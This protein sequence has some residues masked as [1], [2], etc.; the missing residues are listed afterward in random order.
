[1]ARE[2]TIKLEGE[3]S[4]KLADELEV[5]RL[6]RDIT[7]AGDETHHAVLAVIGNREPATHEAHAAVL[8]QQTRQLLRR[9]D[10]A[11]H[12]AVILLDG[13]A[14]L[15][16]GENVYPDERWGKTTCDQCGA[17]DWSPAP[18]FPDGLVRARCSCGHVAEWALFEVPE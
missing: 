2:I 17:T 13:L 10:D 16:L 7:L 11:R 15:V 6:Y 8:E 1:M 12:D 14:A 5:R 18:P 9:L 3:G 4:L